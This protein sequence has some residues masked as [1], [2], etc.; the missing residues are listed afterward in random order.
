MRCYAADSWPAR[1]ERDWMTVDRDRTADYVAGVL[2]AHLQAEQSIVQ[3][4]AA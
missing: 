2:D 1:V 4:K 3:V